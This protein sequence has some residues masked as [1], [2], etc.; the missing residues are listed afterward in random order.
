M[1]V[2]PVTENIPT[3]RLLYKLYAKFVKKCKPQKNV[4]IAIPETYF[5]KN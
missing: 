1:F 5:L 2:N 3:F 4:S